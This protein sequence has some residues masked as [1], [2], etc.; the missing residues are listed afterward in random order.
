MGSPLRGDARRR[1]LTL[2]GDAE[3]KKEDLIWGIARHQNMKV[4]ERFI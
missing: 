4:G 1:P 2:G 3:K